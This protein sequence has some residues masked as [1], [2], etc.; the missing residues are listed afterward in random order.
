MIAVLT[1]GRFN[2]FPVTLI[3]ALVAFIFRVVAVQEHWPSIVP[4]VPP[5]AGPGTKH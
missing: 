3:A 1:A 5:A 2:P 4:L